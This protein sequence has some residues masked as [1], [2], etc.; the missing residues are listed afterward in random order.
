MLIGIDASKN[1]TGIC[2]R[3]KSK[4]ILYTYTKHIS[5]KIKEFYLEDDEF[6]VIAKRQD[7]PDTLSPFEQLRHIRTE[8]FSD[9]APF[10]ADGAKFFLEGYSMAGSGRITMLAELTSLF[11]DAIYDMG[12]KIDGIFAPSS[13]KKHVGGKGNLKKNEIYENC[14]GNEK[15]KSLMNKIEKD[16]HKFKNDCWQIDVLDA[17]AVSEMGKIQEQS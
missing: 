14:W 6:V 1:G 4:T 8:I 12:F 16:G 7:Y 10:I 13:I 15:L 2:I 9:I 17:W 5:K 3:G 11:K